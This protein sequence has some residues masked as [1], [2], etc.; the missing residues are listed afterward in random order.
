MSKQSVVIDGQTYQV[1]P[2][3]CAGCEDLCYPAPL[4]CLFKPS[5]DE[6]D[7]PWKVRPHECPRCHVSLKRQ[8]QCP[9]CNGQWAWPVGGRV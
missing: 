8:E 7:H 4:A 2:D 6:C 3:L 9:D 5:T 1:G